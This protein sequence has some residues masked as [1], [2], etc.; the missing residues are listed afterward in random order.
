MFPSP[1]L[2]LCDPARVF[3]TLSSGQ[4]TSVLVGIEAIKEVKGVTGSVW[5]I[6]SVLSASTPWVQGVTPRTRRKVLALLVLPQP[7][8]H[9][10]GDT[11]HKSPL[12]VSVP[13]DEFFVFTEDPH[14]LLFRCLS[15]TVCTV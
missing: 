13:C 3:V 2:V 6:N 9:K 4:S 15:Y 14:F 1:S 12:Q 5:L 11:S 10:T 8:F 7:R